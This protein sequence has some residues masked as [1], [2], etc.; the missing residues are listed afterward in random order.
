[1]LGRLCLISSFVVFAL[2]LSWFLGPPA[3]SAAV[4][5]VTSGLQVHFDA[6]NVNGDGTNPSDEAVVATWDDVSGNNQDATQGTGGLQPSF[7][8]ATGPYF[9][10]AVQFGDNHYLS[11]GN[12]NAQTIFVAN[13]PGPSVNLG[14]LIGDRGADNGI[15][16][17]T[18]GSA[19][20]RGT[21][22]NGD[23]FTHPGGSQ[24]RVNGVVTET[25]ADGLLHT[26]T[27]VRGGGTLNVDTIGEYYNNRHYVGD[28]FEI[29]VYDRALNSTEIAQVESYLQDKWM[30]PS[31]L[32]AGQL[33]HTSQINPNGRPVLGAANTI[34]TGQGTG[35]TV[36]GVQF[37]DA[38]WGT[39]TTLSTGVT[40]LGSVA[41]GVRT[42]NTAGT[43]SGPDE[44]VL[45]R[46]ANGINFYNVG[47]NGTL[48]FGN[49]PRSRPVFVQLI[50]SD[51]ASNFNN[52]GGVF[53][54]SIID[55]VTSM[56]TSIGRFQAGTEPNNY[57]A[58]LA[59]FSAM[60]DAAGNLQIYVDQLLAGQHAGIAGVVV[61]GIPEPSTFLIWALGLM[62]LAG[63]ARRRRNK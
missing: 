7:T 9:Q 20:W 3:A 5:P 40:F 25:A 50:T 47:T 14:G 42:A 23:D 16:R 2:G 33:T 13:L 57:D 54:I 36:N 48:T 31:S 55:T 32:E 52:W 4:I 10:P 24:F 6:T 18:S 58:Q 51:A 41:G 63:Y 39:S 60:T 59:T 11:F 53:D 35:G 26:V 43:I 45:E 17:S 28:I 1:M 49:L 34:F 46:I 27:A 44:A 30:T 15:R 29:A 62:G 12:T 8:A 61:L 19:G 37:D 56:S 38:I 22:T 21:T